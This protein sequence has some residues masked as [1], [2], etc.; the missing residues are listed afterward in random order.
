MNDPKP[1]RKPERVS[2]QEWAM[3]LGPEYVRTLSDLTAGEV[4][5]IEAGL[6]AERDRHGI[7]SR[8]GRAERLLEQ[9][10]RDQHRVKLALHRM[11]ELK[12]K[13]DRL[14]AGRA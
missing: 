12:A 2:A 13:L 6:R 4:L 8:R 11:G 14:I 10:E 9:C 7:D 3:G 1:K 5:D